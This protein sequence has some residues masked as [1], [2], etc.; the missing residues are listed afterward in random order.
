[1]IIAIKNILATLILANLF[2]C[3][4]FGGNTVR[5]YND[6]CYRLETKTMEITLSCK[7]NDDVI[8]EIK[9]ILIDSVSQKYKGLAFRDSL[10]ARAKSYQLKVPETT[11]RII[12]N[13]FVKIMLMTSREKTW[14]DII[15][16]PSDWQTSDYKFLVKNVW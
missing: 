16:S 8:T 13:E 10:T 5:E 11:R 9:I 3:G 15:V 2:G 6:K 14:Y 1:M 7:Y 12:Q 4:F